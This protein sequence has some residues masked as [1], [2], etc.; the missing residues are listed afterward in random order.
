[1]PYLDYAA[2]TPI[3]SRIL[4]LLQELSSQPLNP[5]SLHQSGQKARRLLENARQS[6]AANIGL[7]D[8]STIVFTSTATESANLA[9]RGLCNP[10]TKR[11]VASSTNEHSC[12]SETL[13]ALEKEALIE[14]NHFPVNE[15]GIMCFP[16][17][18]VPHLFAFC[19]M[20]VN[21]ETGVIQSVAKAK[22]FKAKSN[23]HW[24]CDLSQSL[25]KLPVQVDEMGA[26]LVL[27]SGHKIY[28][29]PG[30][31]C[32]AGPMV[33]K[34]RPIIIGGPQEDNRRAGTPGVALAV[35]FAKALEFSLQDQQQ[36][37][38]TLIQLE[39][40]LLNLLGAMGLQFRL[41]GS[42]TERVPG[43]INISVEGHE[44]IDLVIALDQQGIQVSPGAAC[45]TGVVA[46]SPVLKG[47][48]PQDVKRAAGGV[49]IS[50]SHQTTPED[51]RTFVE[52]L[53]AICQRGK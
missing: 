41:N 27:L 18:P 47:M 24:V 7:H 16:T 40:T 29:P 9:L 43:F 10:A 23:T 38:T 14:L 52:G 3:D 33:P 17:E 31:A 4:P 42:N 13:E 25:G 6:I 11:V 30:I 51:V 19:M 15:D 8:P 36:R 35:C 37:K 34:L 1:M 45:S 50:M 5:S 26:D 48:F 39:Q 2:T 32:L 12:I 22:E 46:V 21:N 49:R 20:H 44:G 28:G 53:S